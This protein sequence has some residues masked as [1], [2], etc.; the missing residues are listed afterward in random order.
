MMAKSELQEDTTDE[1]ASK[2]LHDL[3]WIDLTEPEKKNNGAAMRKR[4]I[5]ADL[6]G[7]ARQRDD[8]P[9]RARLL[10]KDQ[11]KR[12]AHGHKGHLLPLPLQDQTPLC[13]RAQTAG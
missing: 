1:E 10:E 8:R 5:G 3:S 4:A 2:A 12:T 6:E 9:V 7:G 11:A 13:G